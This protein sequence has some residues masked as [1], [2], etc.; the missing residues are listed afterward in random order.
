M[1]HFHTHNH[2]LYPKLVFPERKQ[3]AHF[4]HCI[5]S[6]YYSEHRLNLLKK[7]SSQFNTLFLQIRV[8]EWV[9]VGESAK[10]GWLGIRLM[11]SSGA[12]CLST[13]CCFNE[14]ALQKS[15]KVCWIVQSRPYPLIEN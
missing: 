13:D 1:G 4:V 15:N 2:K 14:L 10:T 12:T 3:M 11:C 5:K 8:S 6:E 9:I 7:K